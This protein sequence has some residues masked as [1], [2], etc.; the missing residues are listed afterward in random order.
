MVKT[1]PA[2]PP[3]LSVMP[4]KRQSTQVR[5]GLAAMADGLGVMVWIAAG[6]VMDGLS[7]WGHTV[8]GEGHSHP[9]QRMSDAVP[10]GS[11]SKI[12]LAG[13]AADEDSRDG[14]EPQRGGFGG[15]GGQ[16]YGNDAGAP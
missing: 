14:C 2:G 12:G 13:H 15:T 10:S 11:H 16:F 3:L 9:V 8:D 1:W 6:H 7:V 5:L 4:R